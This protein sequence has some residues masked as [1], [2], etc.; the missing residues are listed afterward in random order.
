MPAVR[1]ARRSRYQPVD[2]SDQSSYRSN[3]AG[4]SLAMHT[5]VLVLVDHKP[6]GHR[7]V[8]PGFVGHRLAASGQRR[9]AAYDQAVRRIHPADYRCVADRRCRQRHCPVADRSDRSGCQTILVER[10]AAVGRVVG[11]VRIV[12]AAA[13]ARVVAAV[14][15]VESVEAVVAVEVVVEGLVVVR[16][17]VHRLASDQPRTVVAHRQCH[18]QAAR[19]DYRRQTGQRHHQYRDQSAHRPA[20]QA[21]YRKIPAVITPV[22]RKRPFARCHSCRPLFMEGADIFWASGD[23]CKSIGTLIADS[24]SQYAYRRFFLSQQQIK[25]RAGI[26]ALHG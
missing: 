19:S 13:A 21:C 22:N 5:L 8:G 18:P 23:K 1:A 25:N 16:V 6:V 12:E 10:V 7:P 26:A 20:R 15:A 2:R 14:E 9:K 11:I 3:P 4:H 17:A 24:Q